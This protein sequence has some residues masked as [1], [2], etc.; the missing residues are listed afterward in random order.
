MGNETCLPCRHTVDVTTIT[1]LADLLKDLHK[2][3]PSLLEKHEVPP[4]V[5]PE[6]FRGAVESIR[7]TFAATVAEKKKFIEAVLERMKTSGNVVTWEFVGTRGRH[8]YR[9]EL[10]R[11]RFVSIE[12]KGCPDGNNTT[13]WT[14]PDWADE[15]VVWCQCP[16]SFR[17]QPGTG[18]WKG[19]ANRLFP[20]ILR[21]G[22]L[23]DAFVYYDSRCGSGLRPCP[24]KYGLT[25]MRA[26]ATPGI[27]GQ[28]GRDWLPPPSVYLLPRQKPH[29]AT[30]PNPQLHD[31]STCQFVPALLRTFRVPDAELESYAFWSRLELQRAGDVDKFR[32]SIGLRL[33]DLR[34][35]FQGGWRRVKY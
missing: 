23:V 28:G 25:G 30:N 33:N 15:F 21:D 35:T 4:D 7:G 1:R 22:Q 6:V 9:V 2:Q 20:K 34:P 29:P 24:K 31:L 3:V 10:R 19:L 5:Y 8:D 11:G 26:T 17:H 13:I 14:R 18:V 16:E 27:D 12:A 32:V